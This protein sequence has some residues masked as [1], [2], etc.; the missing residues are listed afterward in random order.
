MAELLIFPAIR[1]A[2]FERIQDRP[3]RVI[4]Y[5]RRIEDLDPVS[6]P[7]SARHV[8]AW[9]A[10][11][12]AFRQPWRVVE[13]PEPLW[14]RALPLTMS[15]GLAVRL[16][17]LL[18]RRR[19]T[20]VTYAIENREAEHLF[21]GLPRSRQGL[22]FGFLRML[23]TIVYDRFA[24]G[25]EASQRCYQDTRTLPRRCATASYLDMLPEC[26]KE[27]DVAK[28]PLVAFVGALE[29]RKG[30]P[31]LL[32]AW[33]RSGLGARGW[34]LQVAGSGPLR[35]LVESAAAT[36]PS[37]RYR[38][39]L[40]R[41]DVH[42]LLAEAAVL[43]LP[44]RPDGRWKEQIGNP[45]NEG[46][47][48]GCQV[49]ATPDSGLAGWLAERGHRVLPPQFTTADLSEALRRAVADERDPAEVRRSLPDAPG[50]ARGEE[51]LYSA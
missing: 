33:A 12:W 8:T 15:V 19:T 16:A 37:L 48:H 26:P 43:V 46:L 14:L 38:G 36:D 39:A 10:W 22:G 28:E 50:R 34:T 32:D 41:S 3:D 9:T 51:W 21:R 25:S 18:R 30:V 44:S 6:V 11:T 27:T 40:S 13:L 35:D 42:G 45:I 31:S 49:V 1:S 5:G 2:D 29:V 24:F 17:D 4:L 47:A 7:S 23:C 20:I